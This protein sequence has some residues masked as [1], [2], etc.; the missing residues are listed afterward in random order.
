LIANKVH[1]TCMMLRLAEGTL[2]LKLERIPTYLHLEIV[3]DKKRILGHS[4]KTR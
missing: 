2:V 1:R 3:M 4:R